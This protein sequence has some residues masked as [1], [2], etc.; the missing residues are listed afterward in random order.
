MS[1]RED[2]DPSQGKVP[3]ALSLEEARE[4]GRGNAILHL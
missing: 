1:E 4:L 2:I 3:R